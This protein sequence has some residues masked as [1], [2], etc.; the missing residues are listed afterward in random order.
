MK[1]MVLRVFL[2]GFSIF[3]VV[4]AAFWLVHLIP[5]DPVDFI[6]GAGA[7]LSEKQQLKTAM[8]WD[9]SLWQQYQ[10]FIVRFFKGDWGVSL[11]S[12]RPVLEEL[13]Q[14]VPVTVQLALTTLMVSVL[15][16]LPLAVWVNFKKGFMDRLFSVLS[17]VFMSFPVFFVA[18]VL[19]WVFSIQMGLLPVSEVGSFK[20]FILPV[21]SLTLPLG[22]VLFKM[23]RSCMAEVMD[24]DYIRTARA[25]GVSLYLCHFKHGLKNAL[26][27]IVT[28]VGLQAGAM[29]TGTVIVESIFD[30]PGLGL[31]LLNAIQRRDYP[32]VQGCILMMAC[33]YVL[34]NLL[35]DLAYRC[36]H[37]KMRI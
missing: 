9:Q 34:V 6:L 13:K 24:K 15:W 18:P 14:A 12:E 3:I 32:L 10:S 28:V 36:V 1:R 25:K 23:S 16:A 26:I 35:T 19:V 5:G 11:H 22:A 33:I 7:A 30:W 29:L 17:L 20:H 4:S 2:S 21:L 8:G 31:L 37:P 27:P